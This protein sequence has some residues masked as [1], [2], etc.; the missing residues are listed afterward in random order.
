MTEH[1]AVGTRV[2]VRPLWLIFLLLFLTS[3]FYRVVWAW[4]MHTDLEAFGRRCPGADPD[5]F[6]PINANPGGAG[7]FVGLQFVGY[8]VLLA[9]ALPWGATF[10]P[11]EYGGTEISTLAHVIMA[12]IGL[13]LMAPGIYFAFRT[14]THVRRA[15][16]LAG[17]FKSGNTASSRPSATSKTWAAS[18]T[19]STGCGGASGSPTSS[20][21]A[22]TISRATCSPGSSSAR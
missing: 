7:A 6:Q 1:N 14:R 17:L 4:R 9:G 22:S 3:S 11:E 10:A 5:A 13:A 15:R 2:A 16:E 8:A 12:I 21:L 20:T 19:G 18:A